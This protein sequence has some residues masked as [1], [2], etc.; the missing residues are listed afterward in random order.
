MARKYICDGCVAHSKWKEHY[1]HKYAMLCRNV[2]DCKRKNK[3]LS[4]KQSK[5]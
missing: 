5:L 2:K 4:N 1:C 3:K